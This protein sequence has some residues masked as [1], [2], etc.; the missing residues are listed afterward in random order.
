MD[1]WRQSM[2]YNTKYQICML[3]RLTCWSK[4]ILF[5]CRNTPSYPDLSSQPMAAISACSHKMNRCRWFCIHTV[6]PAVILQYLLILVLAAS[7]LWSYP[8]KIVISGPARNSPQAQQTIWS[9]GI[10]YSFAL[11]FTCSFSRITIISRFRR[12]KQ[13]CHRRLYRLG[14]LGI[15]LSLAEI[16]IRSSLKPC[17]MPIW[18]G[19][20]RIS[21]RGRILSLEIM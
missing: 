4:Q 11:K 6:I 13:C 7:K 9:G 12:P 18:I 10:Q 20:R 2:I 16:G 14:V 21:T 17:K 1:W 15:H 3:N 8:R 5:L 19:W